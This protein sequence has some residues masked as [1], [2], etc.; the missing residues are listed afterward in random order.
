M[1]KPIKKERK[2]R[3]SDQNAKARKMP[4]PL[5]SGGRYTEP[6]KPPTDEDLHEQILG[7]FM[8]VEGFC[9]LAGLRVKGSG[10]G[11]FPSEIDVK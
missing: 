4:P 5:L 8:I 11:D 10:D 7:F 1:E 9:R 3:I 6:R 2:R